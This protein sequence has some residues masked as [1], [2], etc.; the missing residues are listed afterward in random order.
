MREAL[1]SPL[2][3]TGFLGVNRHLLALSLYRNNQFFLF[4]L[5]TYL[6][7]GTPRLAGTSDCAATQ[8]SLVVVL[9][10]RADDV[11]VARPLRIPPSILAAYIMFPYMYSG[12]DA[13]LKH[14]HIGLFSPLTGAILNPNAVPRCEHNDKGG[15]RIPIVNFPHRWPGG[16][17]F[18]ICYFVS[19]HAAPNVSENR[20]ASPRGFLFRG[21]WNFHDVSLAARRETNENPTP[22]SHRALLTYW[23]QPVL[24]RL[25]M[26]LRLFAVVDISN[27]FDSF[28]TD[29][30]VGTK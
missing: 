22:F 27:L 26:A 8:A 16:N 3:S 4:T 23:V 7:I 30:A 6:T 21:I 5:C 14:S 29:V 18:G 13:I 25:R 28:P 1:G 9:A 10:A 19:S 12:L 15:N 17:P 24:S 11:M 20:S 2:P